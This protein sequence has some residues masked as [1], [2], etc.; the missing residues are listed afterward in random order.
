M[1]PSSRRSGSTRF[2]RVPDRVPTVT[3]DRR[4][5]LK[6]A[7][8]QTGLLLAGTGSLGVTI[9]PST[10][11]APA[12]QKGLPDVVVIGAGVLGGWTALQLQ[13]MGAKVLVV[14]AYGAGNSRSTSG[15]E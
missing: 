6:A 9:Q 10:G 1:K 11:I 14:D 4:D 8:A 13:A 2:R 5:F 3:L 12:I 15:D 7:G